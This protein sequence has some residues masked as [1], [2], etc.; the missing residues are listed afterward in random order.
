[1]LKRVSTILLAILSPDLF[2]IALDKIARFIASTGFQQTR[3]VVGYLYNV[4]V[5][6]NPRKSLKRLLPLL[7][8]SICKEIDVYRVGIIV[9]TKILPGDR[10]LVWNMHLLSYSLTEIK[11]SILA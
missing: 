11:D 9:D 6:V 4:L 3:S 10:I 8:A 2:N 1:M 7:I 5:K